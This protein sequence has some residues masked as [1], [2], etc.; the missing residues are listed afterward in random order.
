M[1]VAKLRIFENNNSFSFEN[2]DNPSNR[3]VDTM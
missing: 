1:E 2:F 3:S